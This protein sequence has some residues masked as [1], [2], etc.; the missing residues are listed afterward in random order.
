MGETVFLFFVAF[1]LGLVIGSFLNV[2]IYRL[3]RGKTVSKP[4]FS[5]CPSCGNRIKWY[6]NIPVLSYIILRGRCRHCN[7][8]I[9][10]R[11]PFVEL[12]TGLASVFSFM[13]TGFSVDYIF[14]FFFLCLMIS[15][16]FI[17]ID[18]RIIPDQ[19]NLI[20]FAS[21]IIYTLFRNDFSLVDAVIGSLTGAGLLFG[22]AYFYLKLRG[23]E[24]LGMGDVK[25][26]AFVGSYLGWFGSLFTIFAGSFIGAVAGIIG[27]Y[28]SGSEDKGKFEIPFGPFLA[29][30]ATVYLF[31]GDTIKEWYFGF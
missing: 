22:I 4:A 19:L 28:F 13:K 12:I 21:G 17:D 16:T 25:L 27:A 14:T 10:I 29:L 7:S 24:G 6:D 9:P 15:I 8:Q 2:V 30:S 11:Y 23:I 31:F 3:P 18:F 1:T 20:G 26:M 5:F